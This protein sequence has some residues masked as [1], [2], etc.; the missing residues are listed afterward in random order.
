MEGVR[1]VRVGFWGERKGG[2][3]GRKGEGAGGWYRRRGSLGRRA[4]F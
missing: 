4:L 2:K 1:R 3:G